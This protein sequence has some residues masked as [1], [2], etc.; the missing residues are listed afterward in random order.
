MEIKK[1]N[2]DRKP[3][4]TEYIQSKQDFQQ[5]LA[6]YKKSHIPVFKQ[7]LFYG[8]IGFASLTALIAFSV[9][10]LNPEKNDKIITSK[11][12]VV[13][14]NKTISPEAE[15][16]SLVPKEVVVKSATIAVNQQV[17][18]TESLETE[19]YVQ[20]IAEN[21]IEKKV[22]STPSNFP[23]IS[24]ISEGDITVTQ[25]CDQDGILLRNGKEV[26]SFKF[27]YV[28]GGSDKIVAVTGN[29]IPASVCSE[30]SKSSVEQLVFITDIE[31]KDA[32]GM[33]KVPS[34][35]LWISNKG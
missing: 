14:E 12:T 6:N 25:L 29:K 28:S 8:V 30:M 1:I 16:A 13:V 10:N 11:S 3:L 21:H 33:V 27:Q 35:N 15:K 5:V 19:P 24:G 18:K 2:V 4:E 32:N 31:A 22:I 7:P 9:F 17:Q 34:M 26:V 20:P 23:H